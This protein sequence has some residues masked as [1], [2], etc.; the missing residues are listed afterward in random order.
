MGV[1]G[2]SGAPISPFALSNVYRKG[3]AAHV[4]PGSL[5][6]RLT[7]AVTDTGKTDPA[8]LKAFAVANGLWKPEYER[9]NVGMRRMAVG[10]RLRAMQKKGGA[11]V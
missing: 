5:S 1:V 6:V 2:P 8:K 7:K 9:L 3:T 11:I 10:T 4:K